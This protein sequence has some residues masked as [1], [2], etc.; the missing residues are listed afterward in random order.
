M[1]MY[2]FEKI[3]F[4]YIRTKFATFLLIRVSE[5]KSQVYF[6]IILFIFKIIVKKCYFDIL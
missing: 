1:L 3:K 5:G 6:F 2:T 4:N